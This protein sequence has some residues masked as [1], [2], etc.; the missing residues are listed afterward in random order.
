MDGGVPLTRH[1]GRWPASGEEAIVK[2]EYAKRPDAYSHF[3]IVPSPSRAKRGA[4]QQTPKQAPPLA[5]RSVVVR[6]CP[7]LS[8]CLLLE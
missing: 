8:V 6:A 4:G 7:Y 5:V 2:C 3:S 1:A